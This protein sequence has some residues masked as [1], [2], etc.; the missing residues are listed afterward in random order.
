MFLNT[1]CSKKFRAL[2]P[3]K[4]AILFKIHVLILPPS[5]GVKI[6]LCIHDAQDTART[7][8]RDQQFRPSRLSAKHL[9]WFHGGPESHEGGSIPDPQEHCTFAS[10]RT[11]LVD[12]PLAGT[13]V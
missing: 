13:R 12:E 1:N 6:A 9:I 7:T 3:R 5:E 4:N 2:S 11:E 8:T 10:L